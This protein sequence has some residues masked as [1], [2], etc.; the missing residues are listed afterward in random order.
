MIWLTWR[1]FRLQ[2]LAGL[3]AVAVIA[4]LF[5][6]TRPALVALAA[7]IGYTGCTAGCAELADAFVKRAEDS[8]FA[9]LFYGALV[10]LFAGPALIGLF[11]GAPLV[12][13]ELETGTHRLVWN[14]TVS[15]TRWLAVKLAAGAL[16]TALAAGLLSL[17]ITWW[18]SP[19]DRAGGWMEPY[20]FA[21]RGMVPVAYAVFAFAA[22]VAIGMVLR[23]T[24]V[25]MAVT[26]VVVAA[27]MVASPYLLRP[28][29]ATP[30]TFS[31]PLGADD[32]GELML[33]QDGSVVLGAQTPVAGA[34]VLEQSVDTAAGVPFT[35]PYDRTKCG[36]E[37]TA[38]PRGCHQWV[39]AQNLTQRVVY[40][41]ADK[42]WT[43][44][45]RESGVV[46]GAAV[47]FV[48]F[49][50]WWIRRRVT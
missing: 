24:T 25:A 9:T 35:G 32:I 49:C 20:V 23:R 17:V 7:D 14:Q 31:A 27:A 3:G 34:W 37:A 5:A 4:A 38:G 19:L 11:W 48:I 12:A 15:R 28:H 16:V 1:Q 21:A 41:G 6:A 2:A 18:A 47:L 36:M 26:L 50:F 30:V 33:S 39:A 29:L 40:L 45:W 42:F 22:G 44:Q 46:L 43:L 13:R 10:L 8:Y